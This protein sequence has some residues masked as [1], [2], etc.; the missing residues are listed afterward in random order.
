LKI[1]ILCR[2]NL[3]H[4]APGDRVHVY[5]KIMAF[6]RQAPI[7][8][9]AP[10]G[11]VSGSMT[12]QMGIVQVSPAG[13]RF[14]LVLILILFL[15]R[16]EYDCIY[17]HDPMLMF[18]AAP[19]KILGKAL[20]L[21]MNGVPSLRAG[22]Y[23]RTQKVKVP[24]LTPLVCLVMRL[25]EFLVL[26]YV[27]LVLPVTK[28]MRSNLLREYGVDA[29]K[30]IMI[31]NS[32]DTMV[33]RSLENERTRIRQEL[34]VVNETVVLYMSTFSA[35]WRGTEKLFRVVDELQRKRK[36]IVLLVVGS[37]P[38]LA[39]IKSTTKIEGSSRMLFTGA[40]D[41]RLVPLYL[42]AADVYVYDVAQVPRELVE[43]EGSCPSKILESMACGKPVIAPAVPY[44]IMLRKSNSGLPAHSIEQVG[45]LVERFAD[46]PRLAR[47]MGMN[48]RRYVE[49]NH[50]LA[51]LTR[52]TI[53][54]ISKIVS[55]RRYGAKGLRPCSIDELGR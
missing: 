34:G 12:S 28:E 53:E 7:I 30:A 4:L 14:W 39:E 32:V 52:Y 13:L 19:L 36:D 55:S 8:L 49:L 6:A 20:I 2:H 40:V 25:I 51:R 15:H 38:L 24:G 45:E 46:S 33:F 43:K 9:F 18:F 16:N 54:L 10:W 31:P 23:R 47:S 29:R 11:H 17:S 1:A 27:D 3:S 22:L 21:E 42:N 5:D 37:G 26:R 48:G 50:D 44:E 35:R 41:H